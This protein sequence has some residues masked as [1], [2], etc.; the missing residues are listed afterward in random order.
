MQQYNEIYI[1]FI[2]FQQCKT[3]LLIFWYGSLNV[4]K[5]TYTDMV[6][7]LRFCN[8]SMCNGWRAQSVPSNNIANFIDQYMTYES[9]WWRLRIPQK[10][11]DVHF[12]QTITQMYLS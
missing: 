2:L 11:N 12:G 8:P 3:F 9:F 10:A 1:S 6:K 7:G 4:N 5:V